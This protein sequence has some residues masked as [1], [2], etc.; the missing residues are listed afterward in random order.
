MRNKHNGKRLATGIGAALLLAL[1]FTGC[2]NATEQAADVDFMETTAEIVQVTTKARSAPSLI[3]HGFTLTDD[4]RTLLE[5]TVAVFTDQ[6]QEVGFALIDVETGAALS[7]RGD[8]ELYSAS[9]IKGPYVI[10]LLETG[11]MPDD[12]MYNAI[13]YSDNDAYYT[14]RAAYGADVF[15]DWLTDAGVSRGQGTDY[16]TATTPQDLAKMWRKMYDYFSGDDDNVLWAEEIFQD[17]MNSPI[18]TELGDTNTVLSKCGWIDEGGYYNVLTD[19]G[20]VLSDDGAC[21]LAVLSSAAGME[22]EADMQSLV[23]IIDDVYHQITQ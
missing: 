5:E 23:G 4:Q 21:V 10:S 15:M 12:N 13:A 16:Y 22:G 8:L 9:A 3:M 14:L 18:S 6:G 20:I 2:G 17:T 1:T 19:G 11:Y 7:Y